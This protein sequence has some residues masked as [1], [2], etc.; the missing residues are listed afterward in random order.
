MTAIPYPLV[1]GVRHSF[2]DLEAKIAGQIFVGFKSL[3]Y[4]R[5]RTR[6][7][8]RGA[9]PDPLGK[10]RGSNDYDCSCEMLL[11]EMNFLIALLTEA[12][13]GLSGYGDQFFTVTA[14]YNTL[15]FDPIIDSI[16]G[17]TLDTTECDNAQGDDATMR[18]FDLSPLK[19]LFDGNDDVTTPLTA[20]A[21]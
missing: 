15:G 21:T 5:K 13:G 17:C 19:I 8:V 12:A 18:T 20:P 6:T 10:T 1:T 7:K 9:H 4:S 2:P 14:T 16:L 11:A 3:K